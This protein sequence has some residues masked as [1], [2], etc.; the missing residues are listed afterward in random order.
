LSSQTAGSRASRSPLHSP[1]SIA[2]IVSSLNPVKRE[3]PLVLWA[4]FWAG[5]RIK[6]TLVK[7]QQLSFIHY[8]R[9]AVIDRFPD[10]VHGEK[11]PHEHLLF[12]SN[13]KRHLG[14]VHRCLRGG[15]PVSHEGHVGPGGNILT[16]WSQPTSLRIL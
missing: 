2:A 3:G 4:V 6:E 15:R 1:N 5:Q 8:A 12:E 11:V 14:S 16:R 9:W 7:L 10:E 13:F